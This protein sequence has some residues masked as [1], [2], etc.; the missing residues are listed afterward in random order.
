MST[1]ISD[2]HIVSV[3]DG[4]QQIGK[5]LWGIC[6]E[7]TNKFQAGDYICTSRILSITPEARTI[8]TYSGSTYQLIGSGSESDIL[9]E[10]FELLRQGFNPNEIK[11]LSTKLPSNFH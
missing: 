3:F 6:A 4:S 5:I 7:H 8:E 1:K 10:N 2:W 9:I 11:E